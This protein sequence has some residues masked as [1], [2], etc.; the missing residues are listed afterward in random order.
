MDDKVMSKSVL[1]R[2][3]IQYEEKIAQLEAE[4]DD[5]RTACKYFIFSIEGRFDEEEIGD[6]GDYYSLAKKLYMD[7]LKE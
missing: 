7:A 5:L 2:L 3:N 6:A 1:R 4:N